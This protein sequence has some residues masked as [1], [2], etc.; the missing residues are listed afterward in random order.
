VAL[1]VHREGASPNLVKYSV[2]ADKDGG[3]L[4]L[5]HDAIV[6]DCVNGPLRAH[7]Q[8][9]PKFK[10]DQTACQHLLCNPAMRVFMTNQTLARVAVTAG[11]DETG[12]L[13]L[14]IIAEPEA[15]AIFAM[16]FRHSVSA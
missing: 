16:E 12:K 10:D 11:R 9:A 14:R 4:V 7:I 5:S 15:A 6:K 2:V 13:A 1:T 8:R 3:Q